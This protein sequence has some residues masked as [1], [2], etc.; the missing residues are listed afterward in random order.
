MALVPTVPP[1]QLQDIIP[2]FK[3]QVIPN[4]IVKINKAF[5]QVQPLVN[6]A[7]STP[8]PYDIARAVFTRMPL[9][10]PAKQPDELTMPDTVANDMDIVGT[11][12]FGQPVFANIEFQ[13]AKWMDFDGKQKAFSDMEFNTVILTVQQQKNIIETEIQGSDLGAVLEYSG[14]RN[15]VVMCD[16]VITSGVNGLY[17]TEAM[18]AITNMLNAPIPIKVNC[19]YLQQFDIYDLVVRDYNVP[20]I[21]G[22]ISQQQIQIT[23][24]S[25]NSAILV[26]Q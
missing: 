14:L 3:Q 4:A 10:Q 16:M 17:P 25:S 8:S 7:L 6:T 11:S 15:Y 22:G 19:W 12:Y 23:F 21:Q 26:V 2:A 24:S 13:G 5:P 18:A 9:P 20:Q 1:V